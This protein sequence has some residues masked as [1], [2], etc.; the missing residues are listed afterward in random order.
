MP[1]GQLAEAGGLS[2]VDNRSVGGRDLAG[3]RET[4]RHRGGPRSHRRVARAL[5]V[6]CEAPRRNWRVIGASLGGIEAS[7]RRHRGVVKAASRRRR[8]GIEASPSR[9]VSRA[10]SKQERPPHSCDPQSHRQGLARQPLW[11][12]ILDT[13]PAR[14]RHRHR[15]VRTPGW[16]HARSLRTGSGQTRSLRTGRD[17]P[18]PAPIQ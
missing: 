3:T 18:R 2:P 14:H 16:W 15:H 6:S 7:P 11:S 1:A 13:A 9:G 4:R 17:G 12:L 10:A 5:L 8:G